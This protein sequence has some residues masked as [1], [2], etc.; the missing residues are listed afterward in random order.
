MGCPIISVGQYDRVW[1]FGK[2]AGL[3]FSSGKPVPI[4]TNIESNEGAASI[5]DSN[6]RLLFYTEGSFV[7][8]RN[9]N[10]MPNGSNL[11][12]SGEKATLSCTQGTVIVPMPAD[13]HLYYV[14]SLGSIE[15]SASGRLFY[16]IVDM[17]LNGGLGDVVPGKKGIVLDSRLTEKMIAI[18]GNDCNIWLLVVPIDGNK[19][20]AYNI[21]QDSIH[22]SPV[23]SEKYAGDKVDIALGWMAASNDYSKVALGKGIYSFSRSTGKVSNPLL[24]PLNQYYGV[25]FSPDDSKLYIG[26]TDALLQFDLSLGDSADIV[27]SK[28][29]LGNQ[30]LVLRMGPD[31]KIYGTSQLYKLS[32]IAYPNLAGAAC[33]VSEGLIQ[34]EPETMS[35]ASL[36]A[37]IVHAEPTEARFYT[38]R[39]DTAFC[40]GTYKI[41]VPNPSATDFIWNTGDTAEQLVITGPGKYWVHYQ[42]RSACSISEYVDTITVVFDSTPRVQTTLTDA[43]LMCATDTV[44]LQPQ[45]NSGTGYL[46]EDSTN[47]RQRVITSPGVY[48]VQYQVDS[49]CMRY[50]DSFRVVFSKEQYAVSFE[51][52]SFLCQGTEFSITNTSSSQFERWFWD[53]D[54]GHI[55]TARN[56]EHRYA[57]RGSYTIRLVGVHDGSCRD[58]IWK[59]VVVDEVLPVEFATNMDTACLGMTLMLYPKGSDSTTIRLQWNM[60][61]SS[62]FYAVPEETVS[63]AY[64]TTGRHLIQMVSISRACPEQYFFRS[65]YIAPLPVVNLGNDSGLCLNGSTLYLHNLSIPGPDTYTYLWSTSDTTH[66]LGVTEPGLYELKLTSLSS[67]CSSSETIRVS[68]DCYVDIPNVFTP[69]GDGTNDYFFPRPYL[70]RGISTLRLEIWNRW[71]IPVFQTTELYGRGWD[72]KQN[73]MEQGAGVYIYRLQVIYRDGK[74]ETFNGNITLLR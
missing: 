24:L 8:D 64:T 26:A 68:K 30:T 27:K 58:T 9:H 29:L 28:T 57:S 36:P 17:R 72:G 35:L 4:K 52:D 38:S 46:W 60:G 69:N 47:K 62:S 6:G 41:Q 10:V 53:F 50:S 59:Q 2:G 48:Y 71:G 63:H 61:D 19:V 37:Y 70:S 33:M 56:P 3:D 7:W 23:L 73:G 40:T 13:P 11:T 5:C 31:H 54:D 55:D 66:R 39:I 25:C 65:V 22:T 42:V 20:K 43:I 18:P 34:M 74:E 51:I 45:I 14:F 1:A 44:L 15:F 49:L 16:S 12:G 67:G 21:D 32:V